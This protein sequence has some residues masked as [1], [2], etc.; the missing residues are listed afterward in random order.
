[1]HAIVDSTK[2]GVSPYLTAILG[3]FFQL[4]QKT[5]LQNTSDTYSDRIFKKEELHL[6][7]SINFQGPET[8]PKLHTKKLFG[9]KEKGIN[10]IN[11][12]VSFWGTFKAFQRMKTRGDLKRNFYRNDCKNTIILALKTRNLKSIDIKIIELFVPSE[13]SAKFHFKATL[14]IVPYTTYY[15]NVCEFIYCYPQIEEI[16]PLFEC[17][18]N[19]RILCKGNKDLYCELLI[20]KKNF[21]FM[22]GSGNFCFIK[23]NSRNLRTP[24][25]FIFRFI[26]KLLKETYSFINRHKLFTWMIVKPQN[27]FGAP[28]SNKETLI[29]SLSVLKSVWSFEKFCLPIF[30]K[31]VSRRPIKCRSNIQERNQGSCPLGSYLFVTMN[32]KPQVF[33]D[34]GRS[35]NNGVDCGLEAMSMRESTTTVLFNTRET[36]RGDEQ[37]TAGV[38]SDRLRCCFVLVSVVH[39]IKNASLE[40]KGVAETFLLNSNTSNASLKRQNLLEA[41]YT[42]TIYTLKVVIGMIT[43][44][45]PLPNRIKKRVNFTKV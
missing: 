13:L 7:V 37:I 36:K 3:N 10:G 17:K 5:Y 11:N 15:L 38:Q 19:D 8:F 2:S 23:L 29:P 26:S 22:R 25:Y 34:F 30:E 18:E 21:A 4:S 45:F 42:R 20:L 33:P 27:D 43:S 32:M 40:I 35:H 24:T 14:W 39:K 16:R 31:Y 28:I 12:S 44:T 41:W 6:C 9:I 1:M